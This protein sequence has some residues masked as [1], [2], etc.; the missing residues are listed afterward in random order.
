LLQ[1]DP[2]SLYLFLLC[3]E[4]LAGLLN[5]A[6]LQGELNGVKVC[7]DAPSISNLLFAD[8]SLIVMQATQLMQIA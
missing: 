4:G 6:E 7:C 3:A 1:G 2:L 5:Q 8:D